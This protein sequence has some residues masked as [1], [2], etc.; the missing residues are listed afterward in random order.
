[1]LTKEAR[2]SRCFSE[3]DIITYIDGQAV[4]DIYDFSSSSNLM[5][6]KIHPFESIIEVRALLE[7]LDDKSCITR[8][9]INEW[10]QKVFIEYKGVSLV[11]FGEDYHNNEICFHASVSFNK[12]KFI[13]ST[14]GETEY[15]QRDII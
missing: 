4:G 1:M 12:N 7:G 15:A 6:F 14:K 11:D 9:Y 2:V 5:I 3:G 10:G 13:N 8:G